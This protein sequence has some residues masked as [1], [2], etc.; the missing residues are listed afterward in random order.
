[1]SSSINI[2]SVLVGN[3]KAL[4]T[5]YHSTGN[6]QTTASGAWNDFGTNAG[7]PSEQENDG[8]GTV[9]LNS[10]LPQITFTA[11]RTDKYKITLT[12]AVRKHNNSGYGSLRLYDGTTSTCETNLHHG[13][14]ASFSLVYPVTLTGIFSC[15]EG[16]STTV[17]IQGYTIDTY[18]NVGN[19]LGG[20][21]RAA[22]WII[23]E[24]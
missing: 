18:L 14:P 7:A 15:T 21:A 3:S 5:G 2:S 1:M 8:M 9:T 22:S 13:S 16:V 17:K 11:P 10:N 20:V 12:T 4:Y 19:P 24:L 6:W 23:E